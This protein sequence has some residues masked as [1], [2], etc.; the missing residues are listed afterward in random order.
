MYSVYMVNVSS[1]S[2]VM[3]AHNERASTYEYEGQTYLSSGQ[4]HNGPSYSYPVQNPY[5]NL[6]PSTTV[7]TLQPLLSKVNPSSHEIPRIV[8]LGLSDTEHGNMGDPGS[9]QSV[10]V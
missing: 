2:C 5:S 1:S 3:S 9:F 7:G 6:G 8:N 4:I 10:F